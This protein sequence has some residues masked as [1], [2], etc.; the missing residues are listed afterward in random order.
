MEVK[1]NFSWSSSLPGVKTHT[2][3]MSLQLPVRCEAFLTNNTRGRGSGPLWVSGITSRYKFHT[4]RHA[5]FAIPILELLYVASF[6]RVLG[7]KCALYMIQGK[8][9]KFAELILG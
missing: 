6:A 4:S 3:T 9:E 7:R 8:Q 1:V 2:F 5:N